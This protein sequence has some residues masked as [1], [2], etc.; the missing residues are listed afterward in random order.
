MVGFLKQVNVSRLESRKD[1]KDHLPMDLR[2]SSGRWRIIR[3]GNQL[4]AAG[5]IIF[6]GMRTRTSGASLNI[7][8]EPGQRDCAGDPPWRHCRALKNCE[9]YD[10]RLAITIM[11]RRTNCGLAAG[12]AEGSEESGSAMGLL[13]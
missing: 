1:T 13:H 6:Q 2:R 10:I 11:G 7:A 3:S 5:T 8:R 4:H 12:C 9:E